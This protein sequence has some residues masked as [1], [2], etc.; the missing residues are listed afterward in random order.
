MIENQVR[1]MGINGDASNRSLWHDIV[2]SL[3]H[4]ID[5]SGFA[6]RGG[7][8]WVRI[9]NEGIYKFENDFSA[10]KAEESIYM[11]GICIPEVR[12]TKLKPEPWDESGT[13]AS[14]SANSEVAALRQYSR[15][16]DGTDELTHESDLKGLPP[17]QS[18]PP[19]G[20]KLR[21]MTETDYLEALIRVR[22]ETTNYNRWT[23]GEAG[24][25]YWKKTPVRTGS[26]VAKPKVKIDGDEDASILDSLSM[27]GLP[28]A[29]GGKRTVWSK[30]DLRRYTINSH[31]ALARAM[32]RILKEPDGKR[33]V[34]DFMKEAAPEIAAEFERVTGRMV[35]GISVHFDSNMPHWNLWHCGIERVKYKIRDNGNDRV[36]YRRTA[37]NLNASGPGLLAW[38]RTRRSF[39]RQGRNFNE[40]CKW[41][42]KELDEAE[43][44][45]RHRQGRR[46]GDW[47]VNEFADK[48]LEELLIKD[49]WGAEVE[50]GFTEFVNHEDMRYEAGMAGRGAKNLKKVAGEMQLNEVQDLAGSL[51]DLRQ[52]LKKAQQAEIEVQKELKSLRRL[53]DLMQRL[54]D[55][56]LKTGKM[57]KLL[58]LI[59]RQA[60]EIFGLITKE[61]GRNLPDKNGP[62]R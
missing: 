38:D 28:K 18:N 13:M 44:M 40:T 49:G 32:S 3:I 60:R 35:M 9:P 58:E 20:N 50:D 62:E 14:F 43:S 55:L 52:V 46:P 17:F 30:A 25:M 37:F 33:K 45:C 1:I 2:S 7:A 54:W 24:R 15:K 23:S 31:P 4:Q 26:E 19:T 10:I 53:K 12:V 27:H 16:N 56:L 34:L 21:L 42:Q 8:E 39:E 57:A 11:A 29:K 22:E 41:T 48:I 59:G 47:V 6:S 36:R 51:L 5:K 61:I